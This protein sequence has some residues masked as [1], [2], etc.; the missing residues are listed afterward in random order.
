VIRAPP[1]RPVPD[2]DAGSSRPAGLAFGFGAP[3]G[4]LNSIVVTGKRPLLTVPDA[5][6]T[7]Q[8]QTAMRSDRFFYDE[9]VTIMVKDGVVTLQ[10]IVFD[11]WDLRNA[12]RIA[13]KI[14][15]VR[16]VINDL[17]IKLGGE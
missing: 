15:G 14:P 7:E 9:H 4:P 3:A 10:G 12:R 17:E 16:R 13:R 8:V 11:E 2:V 1:R 6:L 5:E